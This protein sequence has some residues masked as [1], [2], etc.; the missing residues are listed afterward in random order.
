MNGRVQLDTWHVKF[1]ADNLGALTRGDVES[2]LSAAFGAA[3][4]VFN[5]GIYMI[6]TALNPPTLAFAD[7]KIP[8]FEITAY[9]STVLFNGY[10]ATQ[11]KAGYWDQ[12]IRN[13][14]S[15]LPR[16]GGTPYSDAWAQVLANPGIH[17]VNIESWNE[18]DEGSGIYRADPGP[19]HIQPG[20]GNTGGDTWSN[21]NDPLEY[22][23]TTAANARLF[24][25]SPDRNAQILS[26]GLPT[27]M[28]PGQ[29]LDV[30]ITVRNLGDLSWTAADGFKFGQ[31]EFRPGEVLFG[32]GRFLLDDTQ[33]EIPIYGGIFRGRPVTFQLHLVAPG[34]PG[35][36][37][38]HW[39]MLRRRRSLVRPGVGLDDPSR[40]RAQR[41]GTGHL[42]ADSIRLA[43]DTRPPSALARM[44]S[45]R[46]SLRH[47]YL[48]ANWNT[49]ETSHVL[50]AS[51]KSVGSVGSF[52]FADC[53]QFGRAARQQTG[54]RGTIRTRRRAA[55]GEVAGACRRRRRQSRREG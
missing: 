55:D 16:D 7:E 52:S 22:I 34:T 33:D 1:N 30:S 54:R 44:R 32:T 51:R 14:G 45:A 10:R 24:N 13:P 50:Q 29:I 42:R 41:A 46:P 15:Q 8:Q 2:R 11:L 23:K 43:N 39:S 26:Q 18:Y 3:H 38:T 49:Q 6:T 19:P 27:Q 17:H 20:S 5:N 47:D 53:Q 25:D 37:L 40:A 4:P 28:T 48:I 31:Q 36:Y 35:T 12:N 21:T 9:N